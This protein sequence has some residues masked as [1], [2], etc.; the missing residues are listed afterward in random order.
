MILNT[1]IEEYSTYRNRYYPVHRD[2]MARNTEFGSDRMY[3]RSSRLE[4]D[5]QLVKSNQQE[6][7]SLLSIEINN[8]RSHT[9]I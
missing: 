1:S 8:I 6:E 5:L 3:H 2:S 9:K 4:R 7:R